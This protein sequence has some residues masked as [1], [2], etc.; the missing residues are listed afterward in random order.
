MDDDLGISLS[1]ERVAGLNQF[2]PEPSEVVDLSIKDDPHRAVFVTDRL[3][4]GI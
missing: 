3:L 2:L 1:L 4:A